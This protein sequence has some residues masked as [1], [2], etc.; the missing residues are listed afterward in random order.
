[1]IMAKERVSIGRYGV[2]KNTLF[3]T[4]TLLSLSCSKNEEVKAPEI[5]RYQYIAQSGGFHNH[6][7]ILDTATGKIWRDTCYR[8]DKTG[9][10]LTSAWAEETV[11][12]LS[13]N[14]YL[15]K[16]YPEEKK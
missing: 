12:G 10:C 7:R 9:K 15:A 14:E 6:G 1:M 5:G 4:I 16:Y 3:V 11:I 13:T 8:E 2:M